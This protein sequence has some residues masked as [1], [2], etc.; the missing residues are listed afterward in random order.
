LGKP[1]IHK[2]RHGREEQDCN[3]EAVAR[4]SEPITACIEPAENL[5]GGISNNIGIFKLSL[6]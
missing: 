6:E 3:R 1:L 4:D 5:V 2:H